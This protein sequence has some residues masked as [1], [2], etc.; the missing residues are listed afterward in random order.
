MRLNSL[1]RFKR[2]LPNLFVVC[3][4]AGAVSCAPPVSSSSGPAL[5]PGF[6]GQRPPIVAAPVI[7]AQYP[8]P[9]TNAWVN[10]TIRV[11]ISNPL[12]PTTVS[13]R[14][15][16]VTDGFGENLPTQVRLDD[17]QQTIRV[18][19][20]AP[21]AI[22]AQ[23]TITLDGSI[24][25]ISGNALEA[26]AWSWSIPTWNRIEG[27]DPTVD[28]IKT[29]STFSQLMAL[30]KNDQAIIARTLV[31]QDGIDMH[32]EVRR[33]GGPVPFN[34][35]GLPPPPIDTI[36]YIIGLVLDSNDNP[37]LLRRYNS[38][39]APYTRTYRVERWTGFA[40]EIVASSATEESVLTGE[41]ES[42][43]LTI[44]DADRPILSWVERNVVGENFLKLQAKRWNG[45]AWED[46]ANPLLLGYV[47]YQ[48]AVAAFALKADG[49]P[50][51]AV[52]NRLDTG[53]Q[54]YELN[55]GSPDWQELGPAFDVFRI[56]NGEVYYSTPAST[57]SGLSLVLDAND[58]PVV[59]VTTGQ[60]P[61]QGP[62]S[63]Y[64]RRMI[65]AKFAQ[66]GWHTLGS[67]FDFAS[68][69]DTVS[70]GL[71]GSGGANNLVA[72]WT[73]VSTE[74]IEAR[75]RSAEWDGA[76]WR[77]FGDALP[78]V[79]GGRSLQIDTLAIDSHGDPVIALRD[80]NTRSVPE[81]V[82]RL[83]RSSD[84]PNRLPFATLY[85]TTCRIDV[86]APEKLSATGCFRIDQN[87]L[88]GGTGLQPV[89]GLIPYD[90]NAPLWSDGSLKQRYVV[91]PEGETISYTDR[92]ALQLPI[93]AILIK[94]FAIQAD[95]V[96]LNARL[97]AL[98]LEVRFIV[99]RGATEW[100]FYS[101][102][103]DEDLGD[104]ILVDEN[105]PA[106]RSYQL[107]D[108]FLAQNTTYTHVFPNATRGECTQCHRANAGTILGFRSAQLDRRQVYN[109]AYL[110]DNQLTALGSG[111]LFGVTL[112]A[113]SG[114]T[115]LPLPSPFDT[116]QSLEVRARAYLHTNCAHCHQPGGVSMDLRY[117]TSLADSGLC[118]RIVPGAYDQSAIWQRL[119]RD[120][121]FGPMPPL[122]TN[123]VDPVGLSV[124]TDW[125][126]SLQ[127]CR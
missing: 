70:N 94:T 44:D 98:P 22:P 71:I 85:T 126:N 81:S 104:G 80:Y 33:I 82:Y 36:P 17:D 55:R 117:E 121:R 60:N 107:R 15:V 69:N 32:V 47:N 14:S 119:S 43:A 72:A 18:T 57:I 108:L 116:T 4:T 23:M 53:F 124:I 78:L 59:S 76:R 115:H 109:D 86:L 12:D 51:A 75:M 92:G 28:S 1:V 112:P 10:D 2:C 19:L 49:L 102:M 91:L 90:V 61:D 3:A 62:V 87:R 40:W 56:A 127:T 21:P 95:N 58:V 35:E 26:A 100:N 118:G 7:E 6:G 5:P 50:V 111:G 39:L 93:G 74:R 8:A 25:D 96:Y 73:E 89:D 46:L 65:V 16:T 122:G 24:R 101:Y 52:R 54:L 110:V 120:G 79:S 99:R 42:V 48:T 34:Y 125:I 113:E 66:A 67:P 41:I 30:D 77:S 97:A 13:G 31:P 20:L 37:V 123:L 64:L 29:F 88:R 106:Q 114:R 83:N 27:S 11:T 63:N 84:N 105:S 9:G 38:Y 103:W 68:P 45:V